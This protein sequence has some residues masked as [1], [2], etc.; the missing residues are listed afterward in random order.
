LAATR[1]AEAFH[2]GRWLQGYIAGKLLHDPL[3]QTALAIL[4][5]RE[6]QII[7]LGCGLGLLALWL[8][9]HGCKISYLGC[10]LDSWKVN[11]GRCAAARLTYE[12]IE[13]I[14]GNMLEL[15]LNGA[16]TICAFDVLHYLPPIG[17]EQ[18]ILKLAEAARTGAL[19]LIRTG[20]RGCGWHSGLAELQEWWIRASGWIPSTNRTLPR[21]D[22]MVRK[23]E[24]LDCRVEVT[25]LH[26]I[27][28]FSNYC[29][30]ISST[31]GI[32][33]QPSVW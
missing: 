12:E 32:Q 29:L 5:E 18:M 8:R 9:E 4:M 7:D 15:P 30:K 27:I 16:T 26:G 11:A 24:T 25:P 17:Q 23:F 6:G 33:E 10:D 22:E 1:I 21:L 14:T 3:F 31:H 13:F 2:D 19:V 20:V 28:P